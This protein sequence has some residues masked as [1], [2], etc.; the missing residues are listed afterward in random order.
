M[1]HLTG[2]NSWA[3]SRKMM[4]L[5]LEL[6]DF[7]V[8][9]FLFVCQLISDLLLRLQ[10]EPETQPR[11][12]FRSWSYDHHHLVRGRISSN[13]HSILR[14]IIIMFKTRFLCSAEF[15]YLPLNF[16][17]HHQEQIHMYVFEITM[18]QYD[19]NNVLSD[20]YLFMTC[21]HCASSSQKSVFVLVNKYDY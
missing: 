4:Y 13:R 5:Y 9:C 8:S 20:S 17:S 3:C 7:F 14:T 11:G 15:V 21:S 6:F 2:N 19:N 1:T 16:L 10:D 18:F 12:M